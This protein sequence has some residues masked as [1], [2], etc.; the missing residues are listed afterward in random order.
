MK[1]PLRVAV[2]LAVVA[3]IAVSQ[4]AA[5]EG[6]TVSGTYVATDFGTTTCVPVGAS[7][8]MLRCRTTGFV[9]EYGGDLE[10]T[11]I[12]D[13]TELIDCKTSRAQGTGSETFTGSVRGVG[14]G[15]LAYTDQFSSDFDCTAFFPFNLDLNSVAVTGAGALAHVQGKLH[16]DD[17]TYS[18]NLH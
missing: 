7:G 13:F 5:G 2:A 9:S 18:G 17:T 6:V 1:L 14:A 11:A 15:T 3:L 8:F 16:F 4:A 12:A 10:G